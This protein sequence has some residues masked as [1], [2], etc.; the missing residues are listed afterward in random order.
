MSDRVL[1]YDGAIPQVTDILNASKFGMV[2]DSFLARAVLGGG[3]VVHGLAIA[4]GGVGAPLTV[5]IG[6]G[7]IYSLDN[8][9]ATAYGDLGTDTATILKQGINYTALSLPITPPSTAG[10]SQVFLVQAKLTDVDAGAT[11]LSYYNA[12]SPQD[13]YSGPANNGMSQFTTRTVVA[14]ISTV[15]GVAA[16]T[17]SQAAPSPTTG[18]LGLYTI[19]VPNGATSITSGMIAQPAATPSPRASA[20]ATSSPF[21]PTLPTIPGSVQD[22][23]WTYAVDTSGAAN[24]IV[25]SLF[26]PVATLVPGMEVQIKIANTNTSSSVTFNLNGTGA[27]SVRRATTGAPAASDLVAGMVAKFVYD[28]AYWQIMNY[29]GGNTTNT[30]TIYGIPYGSDSSSTPNT[31]TVT[32]LTNYALAAGQAIEVKI[33]NANTGATT[34]TVNGGAS[35]AIVQTGSLRPLV[36]GDLIVG[37]VALLIYDGTQWQKVNARN[38]Y[39]SF[40]LSSPP[41]SDLIMQVGDQVTITFTNVVSIPLHIACPSGGGVF[42]LEWI[43]TSNAATDTDIEFYPNNT[44]YTGAFKNWKNVPTDNGASSA[45]AYVA[46]APVTALV[47]SQANFFF[48][49]IFDGPSGNDNVNTIGPFMASFNI[50]TFTVAKMLKAMAGGAGGS[51]VH[52]CSWAD[53]TTAWSS[54]GTLSAGVGSPTQAQSGVIVVKRVA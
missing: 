30:T 32:G 15:A 19:T 43:A 36:G 17:G 12:N 11:T 24:V 35:N 34:I 53:T 51:G 1:V 9:D 38:A 2:A 8:V 54:L 28:G 47:N 5:S 7:S 50:S 18:Y 25:A 14:S 33:G 45:S 39:Q 40:D 21:F 4:P 10:Y 20:A 23:S 3:T 37:E 13:P 29:E 16:P 52:F 6:P 49:D 31:V 22:S 26:P 41:S 46:S 48:V 42:N 44:I 27:I